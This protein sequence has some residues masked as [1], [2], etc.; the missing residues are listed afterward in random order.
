MAHPVNYPL[1]VV[2]AGNTAV[3]FAL[4]RAEGSAPRLMR[5]VPTTRL[6][7]AAAKQAGE[8]AG[9][10]VVASV[11]PTASRILRRAFPAAQFISSGTR[12]GFKT[13]VDRRTIGSDRLANVAAA[14]ARYGSNVLVAS[15]GTAATFDII[16]AGGVHRGGA[17]APG[18]KSFADILPSRTALLPRAAAEKAKRIT[19]RNTREAVRAGVAGGYAAMVSQLITRMKNEARMK[20]LR[21]IFT[22]GDAAAVAALLPRKPV[23][24]PLLTLRGTVILARCTTRKGRK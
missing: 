6:T 9:S 5:S 20:K 18:W 7:V 1:L 12:T 21:V 13:L 14:H 8:R 3:K 22:G 24:D 17:I 2:D 16:D 4:V 11:V 19:G 15:F 10:V 23:C